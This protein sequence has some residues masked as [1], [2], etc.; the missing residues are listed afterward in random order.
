[1]NKTVAAIL[2]YVVGFLI[3]AGIFFLAIG[4]RNI[5]TETDIRQIYRFL[6]DG[7]SI[8]GMLY[9]GLGFLI[10]FANL[11]TFHGIGYSLRHLFMMLLPFVRKKHQTYADYVEAQKTVSGYAFLFIIGGVF[12]A[13]GIVFTI[14]FFV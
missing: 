9:L 6:A 2:K 5:Y 11:G 8:P 12:F 14:L 10:W 1:M 7:F 3:A 4:M 13:T